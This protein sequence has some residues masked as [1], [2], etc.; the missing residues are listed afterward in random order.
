MVIKIKD[1]RFI[2]KGNPCYIIVDVGANHNGDL[3]KAKKLIIKA[4]EMGAN[5]IKFQ[6]YT[7]KNL[8]SKKTPKFSKDP[9]EPFEMITKYQLSRDWLP[10]LNEIVKI[11]KIHFA[12]STFNFEVVD[13]LEELEVPFYKIASP[14]IVNL[15]LI[16]Y[17]A[18]K[19]KPIIISS[20][21]SSI[22]DV[23]DAVNT[24]LKNDNK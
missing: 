19:K 2:G 21:M 17:I 24:I 11:N 10:I 9:E 23:E 16:D 6:T 1:N 14:E 3:E 4:A 12:S 15:E 13:L 20:C 22:G 5:A 7:A 18:K 8:Y